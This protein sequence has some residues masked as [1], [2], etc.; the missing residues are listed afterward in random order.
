M[1][2]QEDAKHHGQT[3]KM[4]VEEQM[5]TMFI[6]LTSGALSTHNS[7]ALLQVHNNDFNHNDKKCAHETTA[8]VNTWGCPTHLNT[9]TQLYNLCNFPQLFITLSLVTVRIPEKRIQMESPDAGR[10][11]FQMKTNGKVIFYT[12]WDFWYWSLSV[13]LGSSGQTLKIPDFFHIF[14]CSQQFFL[15]HCYCYI[16]TMWPLKMSVR[17]WINETPN[18]FFFLNTSVFRLALLDIHV[19]RKELGSCNFFVVMHLSTSTDV[20]YHSIVEPWT[21]AVILFF[22]LNIVFLLI[23]CF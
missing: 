21:S 12:H 9:H 18:N 11:N 22:F 7:S 14:R 5:Q 3:D 16:L 1:I 15:V 10:V 23:I 13:M 8:G 19:C 17:L 6:V 4:A 20:D 2:F